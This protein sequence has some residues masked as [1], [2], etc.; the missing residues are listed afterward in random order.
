MESR[1][2]VER[3]RNQGGGSGWDREGVREG[4]WGAREAPGRGGPLGQ[5]EDLRIPKDEAGAHLAVSDL[6]SCL[7]DT[8]S[9][10]LLFLC[11]GRELSGRI[12]HRTR[13]ELLHARTVPSL[14]RKPQQLSTPPPRH[15]QAGVRPTEGTGVF[16]LARHR[17]L[18]LRTT[19]GAA[20]DAWGDVSNSEIIMKKHKNVKKKKHGINTPLKGHWFAIRELKQEAST[21]GARWLSR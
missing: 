12:Y 15:R 6:H 19:H 14:L 8:C 7:P 20:A 10:N 1:A 3:R 11:G 9:L 4:S 21:W 13:E 18:A 17:L 5:T 16:C 2:K